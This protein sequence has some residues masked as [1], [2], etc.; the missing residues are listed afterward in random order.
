MRTMRSG[1]ERASASGN[2]PAESATR[3]AGPAVFRK[4]SIAPSA[5]AGSPSS[6]A[7][8]NV[9]RQYSAPADWAKYA[10]GG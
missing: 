9:I 6:I 4:A 5:A 3:L 10:A 2:R 8:A 7:R 1:N